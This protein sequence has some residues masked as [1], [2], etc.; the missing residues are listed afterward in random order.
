MFYQ[1]CLQKAVIN[2]REQH[3][4]GCLN[5]CKQHTHDI[6]YRQSDRQSKYN[7]AVPIKKLFSKKIVKEKV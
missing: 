3:Y 5:A 6:S 2:T 1:F 4:T 7:R